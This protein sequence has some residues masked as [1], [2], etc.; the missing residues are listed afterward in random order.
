MKGRAR[1]RRGEI[2]VCV[3]RVHGDDHSMSQLNR[4]EHLA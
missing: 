3:S 2:H 1:L 4:H